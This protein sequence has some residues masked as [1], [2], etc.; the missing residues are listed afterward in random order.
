MGVAGLPSDDAVLRAVVEADG[1]DFDEVERV[2]IGFAAVRE[3]AR[4]EGG[5]RH[6]VLERRGRRAA[7]SAGCETREFRVDEFGAPPYPEVVLVVAPRHAR[8]AAR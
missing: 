6:R 2:T 1:G 7:A 8:G 3:P 4:R 5:R